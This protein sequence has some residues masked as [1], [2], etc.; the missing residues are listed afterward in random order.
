[1]GA[2][3]DEVPPPMMMGDQASQQIVGMG[4]PNAMYYAA[5]DS[6]LVGAAGPVC[7]KI[8]LSG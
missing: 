6:Q 1:M 8:C 4:D 2:G 7:G 3:P 5:D